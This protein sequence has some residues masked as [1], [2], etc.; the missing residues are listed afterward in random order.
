MTDDRS[1]DFD[2]LRQTARDAAALALGFWGRTIA[3]E[4][5]ADGSV[6][7]EADKAVDALLA[8]RL[9]TARP[10][11]GWL[12]EESA[13]HE[14]RLS[15]RCAWILDPIDGTRA[16]IQ[17]RDDWTVALALVEDGAPVLAVVVNPVRAE[18]FEARAGMGAFLNGQ[19]IHASDRTALAGA[20]IAIPATGSKAWSLPQAWPELTPIFVNSSLYRLALIACAGADISFAS[21]PKWDWDVAPGALLVSEAGG[22]ISDVLGLPLRFNSAEAKVHGFLAAAPNLHQMLMEHLS[23]ALDRSFAERRA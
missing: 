5:K 22:I 4:R 17:E 11:Y 1:R 21:K 12:S 18:V 13:E 19:R 7:T 15:A 8:S 2:L 9:R 20:R 16:F 10:E 3:K 23:G 6:V 14:S